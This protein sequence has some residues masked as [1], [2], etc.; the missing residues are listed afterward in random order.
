MLA[1]DI[2]IEALASLANFIYLWI[3]NNPVIDNITSLPH[4]LNIP[5][6]KWGYPAAIDIYVAYSGFYNSLFYSLN[7]K[8]I[9]CLLYIFVLDYIEI[10]V[11][12][13]DALSSSFYY[14]KLNI[15]S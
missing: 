5:L 4:V 13:E 1:D 3:V 10:L 11:L 7:N 12:L 6:I 15:Y 9:P 2:K 14:Y 8:F